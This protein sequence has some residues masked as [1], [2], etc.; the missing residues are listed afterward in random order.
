MHSDR[1]RGVLADVAD[2][3]EDREALVLSGT[4]EVVAA[5][6]LEVAVRRIVVGHDRLPVEPD[7]SRRV[8]S[9]V[10]A[11]VDGRTRLVPAGARLVFAA[12]DLQG[13]VAF[14][15]IRPRGRSS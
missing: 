13:G 3:V 5:R 11:G 2:A 4:G 8:R 7:R 6:E 14:V 1:H 9:D 15:V 10:A 12:R